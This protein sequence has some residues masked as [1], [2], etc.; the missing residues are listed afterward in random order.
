MQTKTKKKE[1]ERKKMQKKQKKERMKEKE[2]KNV[3]A[4]AIAAAR[5]R[6]SERGRI[7]RGEKRGRGGRLPRPVLRYKRE[8]RGVGPAS[9]ENTGASASS[10]RR[11]HASLLP[12]RR[13]NL[14]RRH[15]LFLRSHSPKMKFTLVLAA[16]AFLVVVSHAADE[17]T[18]EERPKTFRRLIPADVL[19]GKK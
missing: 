18:E 5:A 3:L 4:I 6:A 12:S 15:P 2:K 19:R 10:R 13:R 11:K 16:F 1:N 9:S 14:S 17:K 8:P 7:P